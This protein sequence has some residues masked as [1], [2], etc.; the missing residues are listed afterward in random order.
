MPANNKTELESAI[1]QLIDNSFVMPNEPHPYYLDLVERS[2]SWNIKI[3]Q[4][5]QSH[6]LIND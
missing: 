2:N 5:L 1:T 6:G 3:E 4:I